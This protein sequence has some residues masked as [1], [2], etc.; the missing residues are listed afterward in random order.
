MASKSDANYFEIEKAFNTYWEGRETEGVKGYKPVARWLY[1]ALPFVG[2][3]GKMYSNNDYLMAVNYL[4]SKKTT[5]NAQW[6]SV[7][8]FD[9]PSPINPDLCPENTNG[10]GRVNCIEIDPFTDDLYVGAASG[11]LWKKTIDG[12]ECLSN[13]WYSQGVSTILFDP[14]QEGVMYVGT[15]DRD[16]FSAA[17]IARGGG[18]YKGN[19][20]D[21]FIRYEVDDETSPIIK[22]LVIDPNNSQYLLVAT[23][24]GIYQSDDAGESWEKLTLPSYYSDISDIMYH[25]L[26]SNIV[27]ATVYSDGFFLRSVDG[28]ETWTQITSIPVGYRSVIAT[29][30]DNPDWVFVITTDISGAG[31]GNFYYSINAGYSFTPVFSGTPPN[32]FQNHDLNGNIGHGQAWYDMCL[33]QHPITKLLW[34]GGIDVFT[35]LALYGG[36][37]KQVTSWSRYQDYPA[38]HAD[39]HDLKFTHDGSILY[40]ATDGGVY[41]TLDEGLTWTDISDGLVISQ[42]YNISQ[43]KTDVDKVLSGYQDVGIN[44]WQ[45]GVW[46]NLTYGDQTQCVIDESNPNNYLGVLNTGKLCRL[47][48]GGNIATISAAPGNAARWITPVL[49]DN[50]IEGKLWFAYDEIYTTNNAFGYPPVWQKMT[51]FYDNKA[52]IHL[53]RSLTE[54]NL[55]YI[56]KPNSNN[57][58]LWLLGR[59]ADGQWTDL[60]SNL[61]NPSVAA[62]K[63]KTV[64][65]NN[66][67][68]FMLQ[69]KR[70]YKSED[71]GNTWEDYMQGLP[72]GIPPTTIIS[73]T[74]TGNL[75]LGT[76]Y[77]V[78]YREPFMNE[79]Q[80]FN[81]GLP[82]GIIVTDF[83]IY[84]GECENIL[85][86]ATYGRGLWQTPIP[87]QQEPVVISEDMT[88]D[89]YTMNIFTDITV[90]RGKTLTIINSNLKFNINNSITVEPGA[91]LELENTTITNT[92]YC[93]NESWEGIVVLGEQSELTFGFFTANNAIIS[94][95]QIA[96]KSVGGGV[97]NTLN[98]N[99]VNNKTDIQINNYENPN[100]DC[101]I[102]NN[103]FKTL[104]GFSNTGNYHIELELA[105]NITLRGNT[106]IEEEVV[107]PAL[108][109]NGIY[110][111][112]TDLS[113][114][115]IFF[116][117]TPNTFENFKTAIEV[118]NTNFSYLTQIKNNDFTNNAE[119]IFVSTSAPVI[120][121]N[122]FSYGTS[123]E[124]VTFG[125]YMDNC[126]GFQ[127]EENIFTGL[128][129]ENTFG[130]IVKNSGTDN[131]KIYNNEFYN[132]SIACQALGNNGQSGVRGGLQFIC[133][134]FENTLRNSIDVRDNNPFMNIVVED[135]GEEEL[136][137]EIGINP[138]QGS[139]LT[140]AGN[141]FITHVNYDIFNTLAHFNYYY[142][143]SEIYGYPQNVVGDVT[144][145]NSAIINNCP[146]SS[147]VDLSVLQDLNDS[148]VE[149]QNYLTEL[150][151]I[152]NTETLLERINTTNPEEANQLRKDLLRLSPNLSDTVM[153]STAIIEDVFPEVMV[154]EVL[155]ANPRSSK[156]YSVLKSL[157]N[158]QNEL[159]EPFMNDILEGRNT[160]SHHEHISAKLT[161]FEAEKYQVIQKY[162]H[163]I[164]TD[165]IQ[166]IPADSVVKVLV[167]INTLYSD[168]MQIS[169]Y[170]YLKDYDNAENVLYQ[171]PIKYELNNREQ[172]EYDDYSQIAAI[173]IDLGRNEKSYYEMTSV[174]KNILY[175]LSED[176]L[177]KSGAIARNIISKVDSVYFGHGVVIPVFDST[178][179]KQADYNQPKLAFDVSPNPADEYFIVDYQLPV[180]TFR[181]AEFVMCNSNNQKV[182]KQN[183]TRYWYQ[184]I[185]E[186]EK[187]EPGFYMCKLI[188]AGKELDKKGIIIKPDQMSP[189]EKENAEK[190]YF[191]ALNGENKPMVVYPNPV[192]DYLYVNFSLS[193]EQESIIQ[194]TDVSGK[195]VIT[196]N[197]SENTS[198]LKFNTSNLA[199]GVYTIN[200]IIDGEVIS[201]ETII[202]K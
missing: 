15:G 182:Y 21:S 103:T 193:V 171:I 194:V 201:T 26:N 2:S 55:M 179:N 35:S 187:I 28:G 167:S 48:D 19:L 104:T 80:E 56:S 105:G 202:R 92:P 107:D 76:N 111:Y 46:N 186:T 178:G 154:S 144:L 95:A 32:I 66:D 132:M 65:Y 188:L 67:L 135:N 47:L 84:Y 39:I 147:S 192:D 34:T 57:E 94:N 70:V 12:W 124:T 74:V 3:D 43:S 137:A 159:P 150:I 165:T 38:I 174:Q 40:A 127:V 128:E 199:S 23:S 131:N 125:I 4:E 169:Y 198:E 17:P 190:L 110:S 97:I 139:R 63:T 90:E 14:T 62:L 184:L 122:N 191:D 68:V 99:Y 85:K 98:S 44:I 189:Y 140:S 13:D 185:V 119:A 61:P 45:N 96:V 200:L 197:I 60:T 81:N 53:E 73:D 175:S 181:N 5:D 101:V 31:I 136:P 168:Y 157:E 106:F 149:T 142:K 151:D 9:K 155:S 59:Y 133:N 146:S 64:T 123:D 6:V 50:E 116:P 121:R 88:I 100:T 117:Q 180:K 158:R 52:I 195:V 166:N 72:L 27:Y 170:L 49:A 109:G 156:S 77:G 33:V 11:G 176:T 86:I 18:I 20:V 41:K 58:Q 160:I 115:P 1:L 161:G 10:M 71:K 164:R 78:F 89:S 126:T 130:L 8:P 93:D 173:E 54:N 134:T 183:I 69:N 120:T 91:K 87:I 148:I 143:T 102:K 152:N 37:W 22:K 129:S 196:E 163:E 16:G 75:F 82:K 29:D 51:N 7:G 118:I 141:K 79:W 145:F 25:P 112:N 162:I 114:G 113:I 172:K 24:T 108:R 42:S 138:N 30:S 83:E 153:A 177:S 36:T